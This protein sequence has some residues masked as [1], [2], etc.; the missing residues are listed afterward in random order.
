MKMK[1]F[2]IT[3]LLLLFTLPSMGQS[4]KRTIFDELKSYQVGEGV[5]LIT[6][7]PEIEA[8]IGNGSGVSLS[9]VKIVNGLAI[10]SG[11]RIQVYSGNLRNSKN[12]ATS[13]RNQINALYPDLLPTVEYDAPFWRVRVGNFTDHNEA[14][15][16]MAELRKAFPAFSREMYI[17]RSQVRVDPN[18]L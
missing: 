17:I 2:S 11:Y 4:I 3:L 9:D 14:Q 15:A 16:K 12:I 5:I 6:Q 7:S 13:R 10:L 8:L 1:R 18:D